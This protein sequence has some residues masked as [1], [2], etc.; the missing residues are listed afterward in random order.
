[1]CKLSKKIKQLHK[2]FIKENG[3]EPT[4]AQVVV[5]W[6]GEDDECDEVIKIRDFDAGDTENDP[7]DEYVVYFAEGVEGLSNLKCENTGFEIT[8]IKGF[9]LFPQN[10]PTLFQL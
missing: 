8:K 1:M 5:R 10:S 6:E 4:F 7:D 3:C 9:S 2:E